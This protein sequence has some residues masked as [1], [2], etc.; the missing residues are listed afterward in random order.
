MRPTLSDVARLANV[1]VATASRALSNPDLV[2]D[3]TR[4]AVREAANSCGYKINLVARSLRIQR[5]DTLLVLAP[6][7]DNGFYP[8]LLHGIED[9]ALD[10]GYTVLVGFT[11]KSERH[12]QSYADLLSNGRVDG[13]LVMDGGSGVN[14]FT[15]PRPDLPT[16]QVLDRIYAP[17]VPV[18]R[19]D[20]GEVAD[21]AVRH[22]SSLGHHRIAHIAGSAAAPHALERRNG[23]VAAMGRAGLPVEEHLMVSGDGGW[24]GGLQAM[25]QLLSL[26]QRP[27]A[28][29]CA[30]D[31]LACAA[32]NVC[33]EQ[34]LRV[35]EDISLIG[36]ND[37]Q[38]GQ[39]AYPP[40]TTVHVPRTDIGATAANLLIGLIRGQP[41][42]ES[43][44]VLPVELRER[45]TCA[46]L[47]AAV[48][49]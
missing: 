37:T 27:T 17:P 19:V 39:R 40:L 26:P 2:A 18:V 20:D 12:R 4:R 49:A 11:A 32:M 34:G 29:F 25:R 5:T 36:A 35:P 16:V 44:T 47:R 6:E 7:I 14:R 31:A 41:G 1:S 48:A 10:L 13:M 46:P 28:V 22:L 43:D 30:D 23:F 3:G 21:L 45:A 33:R 24:E 38:D 15:G 8:A 9:A 42:A